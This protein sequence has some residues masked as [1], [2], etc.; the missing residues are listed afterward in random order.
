MGDVKHTVEVNLTAEIT[1]CDD[2]LTATVKDHGIVLTMDSKFAD[3]SISILVSMAELEEFV[4]TVRRLV[5]MAVDISLITAE[6][7]NG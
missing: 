1:N 5:G 2:T 4:E 3:S 7:S 6:V